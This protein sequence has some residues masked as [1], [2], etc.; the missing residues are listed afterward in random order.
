M[1]G[2][3]LI[4]ESLLVLKTPE[5]VK[6]NDFCAMT[7]DSQLTCV[8]M[9]RIIKGQMLLEPS[10]PVTQNHLKEKSEFS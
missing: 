8:E 9:L 10:K 5:V 2:S 1:I 3:S 6:C 7:N 4:R